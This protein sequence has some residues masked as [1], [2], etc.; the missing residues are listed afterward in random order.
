MRVWIISVLFLLFSSTVYAQL[1]AAPSVNSYVYDYAEVIDEEIEQQLITAAQDL[2]EST[3]NE[4]VLMTI[5]TIGEMEPFEFG[6]QLMREWGI[7]NA[8]K[9]NGMLIFATTN[10]GPGQNDVWISVGQ[11]LEGM[12]PDGKLGRMIDDYMLGYLA[13]GDYTNAFANIFNVIYTELGGESVESPVDVSGGS[14]F[15]FAIVVFLVIL[16]LSM[17]KFGGG[18]PGGR[19]RTARR[20]Y[21]AGG[22]GGYY[23][24]G[25]GGSS[26]GGFGGF[27]GGGSAG[28]GAGRSF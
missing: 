9:N 1:P 12:Y 21:T 22:Y 4:V 2:E 19:R 24:G 14:D 26:S 20:A 17:S 7:G 28:G 25:F 8:K 23:G 5:D 15:V 10:Q 6:T 27:G 3:G 11:G 13:N 16:Y 18:G